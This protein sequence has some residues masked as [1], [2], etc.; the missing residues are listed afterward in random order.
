[1]IKDIDLSQVTTDDVKNFWQDNPLCVQGNP[2]E[3]GSKEFFDFF[4]VQRE[5]IESIPYSYSL[6][7]YKDFKDK[8]VLDVGCGNGYV[9]SHYAKEGAN[10]FGVDITQAGIHLCNKRFDYLDLKGDFRVADAQ[11]LP[12]QNDTFDCV[13]SMGV[14]HHV[15]NTQ[16]ALDE[17]WRVLKPGGRLILM[18]YHSHSAKY[19]FKYSVYSWFTGKS[20]QQLVNEFDGVGN[21]KGTVYSRRELGNML[22]KFIEIQMHVGYLQTSDIILRGARFF[23][24]KFFAPLAGLLGWN[25][26]AKARKPMR[27]NE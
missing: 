27:G 18:F 14:L 3:P 5:A 12:F 2:Y 26:Y 15:P 22:S 17:I 21:P 23:P 25:L 4:N 19:Q 10:V 13:C 6:H 8:K 11:S 7:E 16:K 24:D 1:M 20:R 9:L